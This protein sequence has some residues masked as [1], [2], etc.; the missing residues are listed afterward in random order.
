MPAHVRRHGCRARARAAKDAV[1]RR[2]PPERHAAE[3]RADRRVPRVGEPGRSPRRRLAAWRWTTAQSTPIRINAHLSAIWQPS[4]RRKSVKSV[5]RLA[6]GWLRPRWSR[7]AQPA[8]DRAAA[9]AVVGQ[10]QITRSKPRWAHAETW[11]GP[12]HKT[13]AEQNV[14]GLAPAPCLAAHLYTQ[15]IRGIAA[16][17]ETE[18]L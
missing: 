6:F 1:A 5:S 11:H 14:I 10:K 2:R 9:P 16:E 7:S 3:E 8:D 15:M 18:A 13:F 17:G 4:L 12:S